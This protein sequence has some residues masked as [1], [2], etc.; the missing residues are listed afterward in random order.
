MLTSHVPEELGEVFAAL[1]GLQPPRHLGCGRA[2]PAQRRHRRECE[3]PHHY[4]RHPA[5]PA[6]EL[7]ARARARAYARSRIRIRARVRIRIRLGLGL[8]LHV[9]GRLRVEVEREQP[10]PHEPV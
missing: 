7:R 1:L 6:R 10:R 8:R 2:L 9:R 4:T 3:R 5:T